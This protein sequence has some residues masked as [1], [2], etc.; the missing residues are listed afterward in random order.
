[1]VGG[2]RG[3]GDT[4]SWRFLWVEVVGGGAAALNNRGVLV[5][6]CRLIGT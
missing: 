1:M 5:G 3:D 6:S 4:D 2:K